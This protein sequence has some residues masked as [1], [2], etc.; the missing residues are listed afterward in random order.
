MPLDAAALG[1]GDPAAGPATVVAFKNGP[2]DLQ[3]ADATIG[4]HRPS[5]PLAELRCDAGAGME[6]AAVYS[7]GRLAG[8]L[9]VNLGPDGKPTAP[10]ALLPATRI[11]ELLA[12]P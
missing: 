7:S 10:H 11:R 1:E 6:G 3:L 4:P 2:S 8:I 5:N 9:L 12:Q